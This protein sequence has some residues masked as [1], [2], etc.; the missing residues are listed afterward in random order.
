MKNPGASKEA[1]ETRCRA[2]DM[3]RSAPLARAEELDFRHS[4]WWRR[5][6]NVMRA[7]TAAHFPQA[8]IDR[9]ANCGA[10]AVLWHHEADGTYKISACYCHDKWCKPCA[11]PRALRIADNVEDMM[12]GKVCRHIVLTK[13]HTRRP[14]ADQ[15]KELYAQF[16]RLRA[17]PLWKKTQKGGAAF[18]QAHIAEAD[19]CW[20]VHLHVIAEGQYIDQAELSRTWLELTGDSSNVHVSQVRDARQA[21]REVARY[22]ARPIDGYT[23]TD[24]DS[25]SELMIAT[26]GVHLCL[27]FGSWRGQRLTHSVQ[28]DDAP[29][30]RNAGYLHEWI[31][32]AAAG[33]EHAG[34]VLAILLR[35]SQPATGPPHLFYDR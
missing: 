13:K 14:P 21:A 30:W 4:G 10:A 18:L 12:Q 34:R 8:R 29:R 16:K 5:R 33:N 25:F 35:Q 32:S 26:K 15:I 9:F 1:W 24:I 20:H 7:M 2:I 11:S 19:A 3:A 27:T 28:P 22:A 17:H 23:A 31:R 6:T